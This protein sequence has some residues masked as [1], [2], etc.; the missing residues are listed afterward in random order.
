MNDDT[1]IIGVD[2]AG[3]GPLF[4]PVYTSAVIL[5]SDNFDKT[6]IKDSKRFSSEKKILDVY[7]SIFDNCQYFDIDFAT[8]DEIDKYNI[9]QATQ[10]SM[11]RC[12]RRTIN[13]LIES[14]ESEKCE[15]FLKNLLILVDGNYFKPFAYL[16]DDKLVGINHQCVVRGDAIH[17]EI[18]AASILA[19]VSRDKYIKDFVRE[20][21]EYQ[22][23]YK[24]LSN[25]GYGTKEH[26]D[27]IMTHGYSKYHRKTFKLKKLLLK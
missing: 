19:K 8:H 22:E 24:L 3:R 2:E 5:P 1:I 6:I 13:K 27:G 17:K 25:K 20:N 18:G 15:D 11:H 12:I 16:Y 9:L 21:P 23:K 14:V 7:L 4:G 10:Y 26:I